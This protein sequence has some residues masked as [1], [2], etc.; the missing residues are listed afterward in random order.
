MIKY[1]TSGVEM[2]NG[3]DARVTLVHVKHIDG[4]VLA[5]ALDG[6]GWWLCERTVYDTRFQALV[7][8]LDEVDVC[9]SRL[10]SLAS[11]FSEAIIEEA[12]ANV[13]PFA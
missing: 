11:L 13:R 2:K 5:N 12:A 1:I 3:P 8:A 9:I 10:H 4:L 6:R 7:A